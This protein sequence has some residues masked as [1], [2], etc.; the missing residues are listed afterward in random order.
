MFLREKVLFS[1]RFTL[2]RH[3]HRDTTHKWCPLKAGTSSN[4]GLRFLTFSLLFRCIGTVAHRNSQIF[5]SYFHL[6]YRS[7]DE[8]YT[9]LEI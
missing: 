8:I 4:Q 2:E 7:V 3:T 9:Q 1:C 6:L 5:N